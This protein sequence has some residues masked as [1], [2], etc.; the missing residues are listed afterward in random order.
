MED[1]ATD[2]P[3]GTPTPATTATPEAQNTSST[4]EPLVVGLFGL[5][6]CGKSFLTDQLVRELGGQQCFY[7]YESSDI[8]SGKTLGFE[9][10]QGLAKEKVRNGFRQFAVWMVRREAYKKGKTAIVPAHFM[11][12]REG[13]EEGNTVHIPFSLKNFTHILYLD[14][15]AEVIAKRRSEDSRKHR[16]ATSVGHLETWQNT[17]LSMLRDL[18]YAHQI[19]FLSVGSSRSILDDVL[20]LIRSLS[21]PTEEDNT[22]RATSQLSDFVLT[23]KKHLRTILV[24][25]GDRTLAAEDIGALFW[26]FGANSEMNPLKKLFEISPD[27]SYATFLQTS[28]LYEELSMQESFEERC[29]RVAHATT[30]CSEMVE[31][32]RLAQSQA[33]VGVVVLTCGPQRVWEKILD[34]HG[35]LKEVK[36]IGNGRVANGLIVHPALKATLVSH[37]Q[38]SHSLSVCA[39]GAS[40]LDLPMLKIADRAVVVVGDENT[41]SKSM[42]SALLQAVDNDGLKAHQVLLPATVPPRLDATKLPII[43]LHDS[44]FVKTVFTTSEKPADRSMPIRSK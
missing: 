34:A 9:M 24:M 23:S 31:F 12:W 18:C 22:R 28:L 36:V 26:S 33:H 42:D 30:M 5:P 27:Y 44:E 3:H 32:I 11:I 35:L 38:N 6:G 1:N 17:E 29:T 19:P 25:D 10:L 4:K 39:F 2:P 43:Q 21:E 8:T 7:Y 37:L 13:D 41:R 14:V 20:M 40:P 15:P 16:R